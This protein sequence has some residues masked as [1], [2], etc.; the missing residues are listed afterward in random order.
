MLFFRLPFDV[1]PTLFH[2]PT[3]RPEF[4][5]MKYLRSFVTSA[6][7]ACT[8]VSYAADY[9]DGD[10]HKNDFNWI[11]FNLMYALEEL[12]RPKDANSGHDYLE[13]EF[14]GRSGVLD[15]YGYVDVFN[16][17]NSSNSDK[18]EK[19]KMFM[20]LSPRFS[21]D[22]LFAKDLSFGPVRELYFSTLFNWGGG[23]TKDGFSPVNNSFWG[24][25]ADI[26]FPWLG[27]IGLNL[28]GLYDLNEKAW[29]GFQVSTNWFK[30]FYHFKNESFISYQGYID[31]QFAKDE[32]KGKA[33]ASN[34]GAMFNGFYWHSKHWAAGYGLK[35]Y[36]DVYLIKDSDGLKSTGVSHYFS[37]TYKL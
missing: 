6:L 7:S 34:G 1:V 20:K 13:M 18:Y 19:E 17:T 26:A 3:C 30:P 16:L 21:L 4:P 27:K 12:P 22:S 25:G 9:S 11:Q 36:K 15:L 33:Q 35:L 28:Y 32:F 5:A 14:G 23:Y 24:V 29:N 10:R 8:A 31:W 2:Q 37:V